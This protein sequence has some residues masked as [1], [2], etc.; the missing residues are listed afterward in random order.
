MYFYLLLRCFCSASERTTFTCVGAFSSTASP[1][2]LVNMFLT[3]R[4]ELFPDY[5]VTQILF[6]DV[7]NAAELRQRAMAGGISGALLNATMVKYF[8]SALAYPRFSGCTLTSYLCIMAL[9]GCEP[10]P[11]AGSCK[12]GC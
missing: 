6:R 3:H 5:K 12:Q 11:S 2:L 8:L 9:T 1:K 4:L 7:K 10:F